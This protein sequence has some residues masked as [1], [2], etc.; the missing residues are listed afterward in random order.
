[1]K[2]WLDSEMCVRAYTVWPAERFGSPMY[3]TVK[4]HRWSWS[5]KLVYAGVG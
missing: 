1:M 2:D 3:D 5:G 4:R